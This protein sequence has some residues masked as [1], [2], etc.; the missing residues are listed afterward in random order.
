VT[1]AAP[2]PAAPPPLGRH[3][4]L[5]PDLPPWSN[6]RSQQ[7][8]TT[9]VKALLYSRTVYGGEEKGNQKQIYN[10]MVK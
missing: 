8:M 6:P 5:P 9:K 4:F 10:K 7:I 3:T 1:P 2:A